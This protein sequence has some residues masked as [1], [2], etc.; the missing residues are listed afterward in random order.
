MPTPDDS[1]ILIQ[2]NSNGSEFM[3]R[4]PTDDLQLAFSR[5]SVDD[6]TPRQV[7]QTA[8]ALDDIPH[9]PEYMTPTSTSNDRKHV[10]DKGKQRAVIAN[11]IAVAEP[12]GYRREDVEEAQSDDKDRGKEE[13]SKIAEEVAAGRENAQEESGN[14]SGDEVE[15]G[16]GGED[17]G[18]ES[19]EDSEEEDENGDAGFEEEDEDED[20]DADAEFDEDQD[21]DEGEVGEE[22]GEDG[23]DDN[24]DKENQWELVASVYDISESSAGP[25]VV[26]GTDDFRAGSSSPP[27]LSTAA[28]R[29]KSSGDQSGDDDLPTL[30]ST[31]PPIQ[32]PG[33]AASDA[34]N[35]P[36]VETSPQASG[37]EV[38]QFL[39][40]VEECV[41]QAA[42]RAR[43]RRR[44][45]AA[46]LVERSS[47]RLPS[48]HKWSERRRISPLVRQQ[49]RRHLTR[50]GSQQS[51]RP[52]DRYQLRQ[53]ALGTSGGDCQDVEMTDAWNEDVEMRD[54]F[55]STTHL[56]YL[57][58]ST[59]T[60]TSMNKPHYTRNAGKRTRQPIPNI[61][62]YPRS[63]APIHRMLDPWPIRYSIAASSPYAQ[64]GMPHG[65]HENV[66]ASKR[67]FV[68]R[69]LAQRERMAAARQMAP[70]LQPHL[71]KQLIREAIR[72][73]QWRK[74]RSLVP[75][76][77]P[78]SVL[79]AICSSG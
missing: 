79:R 8:T 70:G 74:G 12:N 20:E 2:R 9:D 44:R 69:R 57:P 47:L 56:R 16:D 34:E 14:K 32:D 53:V 52:S 30:A 55:D 25:F 36:A 13:Y 18:T 24:G 6:K 73:G 10:L 37:S 45:K 4:E 63:M 68:D 17:G 41:R 77:V 40:T 50:R 38:D 27:P 58:R 21:D 26:Y 22:G 15:N 1:S 61:S 7:S 23:E 35:P 54:S 78:C 39:Q 5:L 43:L 62:P 75:W 51:W 28:P 33:D 67:R 76:G 42:I 19:E 11:E 59:R 31:E 71:A 46:H 49:V 64:I 66:C 29:Q 60:R 72:D 48:S 3:T 65:T